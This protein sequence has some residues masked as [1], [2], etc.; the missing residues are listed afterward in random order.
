M[1]IWISSLQESGSFLKK[2][3]KKLL[4]VRG[5]RG[6]VYV[7]D[8]RV[9]ETVEF[10]TK[11]TKK[12]KPQTAR[13]RKYEMRGARWHSNAPPFCRGLRVLHGRILAIHKM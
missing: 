11:S 10:N 13:R 3:T 7:S 8:G 5:G 1:R 6:R 2:R 4:L 12:G 9:G